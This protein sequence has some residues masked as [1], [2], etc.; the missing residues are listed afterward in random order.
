MASRDYYEALE[1]AR[2]APEEEI[3]R[4]Y[5]KKALKYHPDRNPDDPSAA[6]KFKEAA[7]A[8]EVLSDPEKR[9]LYD[10]YGEA[11]LSA[12]GVR[13][14]TSYEDIFG[15]FSDVFAG[16]LF[17]DFFGAGMA[18]QR[19]RGRSLRVTL[20]VDM[21]EVA[22]GVEKTVS[23]RRHERCEAC[24]GTGCA[25]GKKPVNCPYCRGHGMVESRQGFFAL[26]TTCPQCRGEG[27]I[28]RDPCPKCRGARLVEKEAEIEV[29]V[30][31]GIESGTRIPIR[32]EGE[33]G[34]GGTRGDLY[35]DVIVRE[36]P[37]FHRDGANLICELPITYTTAC[38]G[39]R[40]EVPTLGGETVGVDIPAGTQ[41]GA[42]LRI[43][44]KGL[45]YLQS[46]T[47]GDLIVVVELEVP[48]KLTGPQKELLRSLAEIEGTNVTPKRKNFLERIKNY[49]YSMTHSHE[50][51]QGKRKGS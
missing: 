24:G 3:K 2:D 46:R 18:R 30:P 33:E 22:H 42:P 21:E 47:H 26:R 50:Q 17:E 36:H 1:V 14:F 34:P 19:G 11:G 48:Q 40:A 9:R 37:I 44:G 15:A 51:E 20:E 7:E 49:V 25:P 45:P 8:Y 38:L 5:R 16:S 4:A 12:A 32:G 41:P 35:C 13:H 27:R 43:R 6:E 31:A 10:M 28:I 29:P 23:L 39:G